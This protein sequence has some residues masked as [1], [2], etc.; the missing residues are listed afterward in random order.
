MCG[1][2][3][4]VQKVNKRMHVILRKPML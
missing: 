3:L 1:G 4:F 2:V